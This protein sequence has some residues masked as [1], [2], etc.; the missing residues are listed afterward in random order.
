MHRFLRAGAALA[1]ACVG[2]VSCVGGGRSTVAV[3][4]AHIAPDGLTV[5]LNRAQLTYDADAKVT[6]ARGLLF[7]R[8]AS[9]AAA[10]ELASVQHVTRTKNGASTDVALMSLPVE[11]RFFRKPARS[12][13]VC[14]ITPQLGARRPQSDC[15]DLPPDADLFEKMEYATGPGDLI[16]G[17][18]RGGGANCPDFFQVGS[19]WRVTNFDILTGDGDP[20]GTCFSL[21]T[22][23]GGGFGPTLSG[24]AT[25]YRYDQVAGIVA[26][27]FRLPGDKSSTRSY[28]MQYHGP[29]IPWDAAF[30]TFGVGQTSATIEYYLGALGRSGQFSEMQVDMY[31]GALAP[32]GPYLGFA[33]GINPRFATVW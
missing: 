22:G 33:R 16:P 18:A 20:N 11:E 17:I 26:L 27:D 21:S 13:H 19:W 8:S 28:L 10:L 2:L 4:P 24:Y 1:F 29:G 31:Q 5:T 9:R 6:A 23:G 15:S 3:P 25:D 14:A 32:L 7:V 30:G 12:T